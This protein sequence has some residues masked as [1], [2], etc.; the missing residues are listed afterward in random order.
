MQQDLRGEPRTECD[1][2]FGGVLSLGTHRIVLL[3]TTWTV[4]LGG[5]F[6]GAVESLWWGHMHERV[7]ALE[8]S[9]MASLDISLA[10]SL[11]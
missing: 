11:V 4:A 7:V 2:I 1:T 10:R 9:Y 5:R 3:V 6:L 8:R